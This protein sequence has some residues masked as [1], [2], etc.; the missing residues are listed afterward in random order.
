M[1]EIETSLLKVRAKEIIRENLKVCILALAIIPIILELVPSLLENFEVFNEQSVTLI[2]IV[3]T[4]VSYIFAPSI[5]KLAL[6]L[7]NNK[8]ATKEEF[9]DG[10]KVI[11]KAIGLGIVMGLIILIGTLIFIIPGIVAL[12]TLY[13]SFYIL[14]EDH[15]KTISECLSESRELTKG[16]KFQLFILELSFIGWNI[17]VIITFGIAGLW[18]TPYV[19]LTEA[20]FYEE[21]KKVKYNPEVIII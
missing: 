16:Y 1:P 5:L 10:F 4:L 8:P 11:G 2:T 3:F 19:T 15:T 13:Y 21:L 14:A 7:V 17:L 18:V 12:Y 20:L 6:S 9:L